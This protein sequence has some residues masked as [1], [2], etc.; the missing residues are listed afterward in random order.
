MFT[1]KRTKSSSWKF[2]YEFKLYS[3][4]PIGLVADAP[5][6][7]QITILTELSGGSNIKRP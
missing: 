1:K 2:W 3:D 6:S 7:R 4:F 5:S